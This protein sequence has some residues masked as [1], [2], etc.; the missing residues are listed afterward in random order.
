MWS[1]LQANN[2][3]RLMRYEKARI[4]EREVDLLTAVG[5]STPLIRKRLIFVFS[6]FR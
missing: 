2:D 3:L 6:H 1:G 4:I 5:G